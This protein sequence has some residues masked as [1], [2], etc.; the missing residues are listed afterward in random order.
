[1]R[2]I[3]S[4]LASLAILFS[5]ATIAQHSLLG[6]EKIYVHTNH[7]FFK[8]GETVYFTLYLLD[9]AS[10]RPSAISNIVYVEFL[11]PAGSLVQKLT[12]T[13]KDGYTEGS[14]TIPEQAVGGIYKIQAYT[15]WMKNENERSWFSRQITVQKTI[16]PRVLMK[17]EFPSKGYGAGDEVVASLELRNLQNEPIRNHP[18]RYTIT[19]EGRAIRE[20]DQMTN[21]KGEAEIRFRLPMDLNS[22]DGM[23]TVKVE[24]DSYTESVTK[25]IP[26][27]LDQ[28][29]L[30]FM[31]ESGTLLEGISHRIAFKAINELGKGTDVRGE[32]IDESGNL[33]TRFEAFHGGMGVFN[34]TAGAGRRYF[35][36]I[37]TPANISTLYPLP[38]ASA[39]GVVMQLEKQTKDSL[40]LVLQSSQPQQIFLTAF[41]REQERFREWVNI[42]YQP[43]RIALPIQEWPVGI[44]R[45]TVSSSAGKP[46]AERLCF[47]HPTQTMSIGIETDKHA[48]MPREKVVMS[49]TTSNEDGPVPAN[50]S[51]AVVDDKLWTMA[52]DKQDHILS[53]LLLSSELSGKIEEPSFYFDPKEKKSMEAID[54][55]MLTHGYRYFDYTGQVLEKKQLVYFPDMTGLLEGRVINE[56]GE[57]VSTRVFLVESR[58][59][60]SAQ[61]VETDENGRFRFTRLAPGKTIMLFAQWNRRGEKLTIQVEQNGTGQ[62][63]LED[64]PNWAIMSGKPRAASG[65]T[66]TQ[67]YPGQARPTL[68]LSIGMSENKLE[69]VVVVAYGT[70]Q[71]KGLLGSVVTI[72]GSE[73]QLT[74]GW[75]NQLEGRVPGLQIVRQVASPANLLLRLRGTASFNPNN[76]PLILLDGI[77]VHNLNEG[78]L[79][80]TIQNITVVNNASLT[81]LYGSAAA[82]GV[83]AV[84]TKRPRNGRRRIPLSRSYSVPSLLIQTPASPFSTVRRFYAPK[85]ESMETDTRNDFRETIYWNGVVQTDKFGKATISFYNSDA[86]TSFRTRIEGIAANGNAGRT[87]Y[88]YASQQP[89]HIDAKIPPEL[90]VGDQMMMP[91]FVKNN[92]DQPLNLMVSLE[93]PDGMINQDPSKQIQLAPGQAEQLLYRIDAIAALRDTIRI[94][95][96][97]AGTPKTT[98]LPVQVIERGFPIHHSI[99][100]NQTGEHSFTVDRPVPGTVRAQ[101]KYFTQLE[102]QLL[103]GIES[104][105]RE[106]YGCFEQTSSTT[107]PNV[108]ILKFLRAAGKSNPAVEQKALRYI[109]N[110][111]NRLIRFETSMGGF[112]WFGK[113]PPHEALT[114]YGLLEFTDMQEFVNV[115]QAMLKR[116]RKYLLDRQDGKG[117]FKLIDGGYD[118]FRSVPAEIAHCYILYSLSEAGVRDEIESTYTIRYKK[119]EESTDF[120]QLSLLALTGYNLGKTHHYA[121]LMNRL[122]K[123]YVANNMR[124]QTSVVSSYGQSLEVE[125]L[126]LYALALTREPS[127]NISRLEEIMRRILSQ[128]SYYGYGSTQ[129]TVL[130]LKAMVACH[131]LAGERQQQGTRFFLNNQAI[132]PLGPLP[133]ESGT[134]RLR[135]ANSDGSSQT[136]PF[137]LEVSY[138]TLQPPN[139]DSARLRIKTTLHKNRT[140]VGSTVRLSVDVSNITTETLPMSIAKIGIPPGLSLQHEQLRELIETGKVAY[141]EIFDNYLVL[142]WRGL[143]AATSNNIQLDLKAEVA[144][145]YQAKASNTYLYYTPEHKHWEAGTTILIEP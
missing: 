16:A 1:M 108:F 15:T 117:G 31:P 107:Y 92:T 77:P 140:T 2:R 69:E 11:S 58:P 26:I 63:R 114:A 137:S 99:T 126:S 121:A 136:V 128:K 20:K 70:D 5:T 49:I 88:V 82:N 55:L 17:L 119:M 44:A 40:Y 79:A 14:F 35:A 87:E 42:S 50:L 115:D 127:P 29:D 13:V 4:L 113:T 95:L 105:L 90:T 118:R 110:G 36:R 9:G 73:L 56:K 122:S 41:Q 130:A 6:K 72:S 22:T 60:Y 142:Y 145:R 131:L 80:G 32:I 133:L 93:T 53:W 101:L 71:K 94:I 48:Y 33:I 138:Q 59:G 103:D 139:S 52:N 111:Y 23:L 27:V 54:L 67:T 106:P 132:Q 109:Q 57:P 98:E 61:S 66:P 129:S 38:Q 43:T 21:E 10:Q 96:A 78:Q 39:T 65:T 19:I 45:I 141:Y 7:I 84:E 8:P 30:Q 75:S 116:T 28:I 143:E 144:G 62:Q 134:N 97:G 12:L 25:A 34:L 46:L 37:S 76:Q 123:L 120:Y 112:E 104:M 3:Y 85:Y 68:P 81:A 24:Y 91:V 74:P 47:L 124:S 18:I 64:L 102:G 51:V 83:I 100:D 86:S 135:I 89:V 125:S